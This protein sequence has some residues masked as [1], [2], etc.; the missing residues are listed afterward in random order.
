MVAMAETEMFTTLITAKEADE[1]LEGWA[2]QSLRVCFAVCLGNLAWHAHWVGTIRNALLGRWIHTMN[3][4]TNMLCAGQYKEI[5]LTEHDGLL[6]IRFRQP[7]GV[8]SSFEIDLFIDKHDGFLE[9]AV[10]LA[11]RMIH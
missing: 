4:T 6:G 8:T 7:I 3:H 9:D 5:L 1:V 10:T 11:S 2:N